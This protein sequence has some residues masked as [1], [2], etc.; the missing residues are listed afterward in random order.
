[1]V[2]VLAEMDYTEEVPHSDHLVVRC[3]EP[4]NAEPTA[5]AL[6]EFPIT[7]D[8][9]VYCRN[10]GPVL[11]LDESTFAIE[12]HG[13]EGLRSFTMR[14]LRESFVRVEVVAALQVCSICASV[15]LQLRFLS[16]SAPATD[17]RRWMRRNLY[18]ES[19]GTTELLR[20][21]GGRDFVCAI[22]F[23]LSASSRPHILA[24]TSASPLA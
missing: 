1:M 11:D 3:S 18:T 9:L 8:D 12:V 5:A 2:K 7:P 15:S 4:F 14:D 17:A 13:P 22:C 16:Y 21:V 6:V 24:G 19:S 20:T 23:R 10:H